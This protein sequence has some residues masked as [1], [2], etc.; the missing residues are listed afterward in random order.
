[1]F[2]RRLSPDAE[3]EM[4]RELEQAEQR[5]EPGEQTH[6]PG[7]DWLA[8]YSFREQRDGAD[9]VLKALESGAD[10]PW[11]EIKEA[12]QVPEHE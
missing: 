11:S 4:I 5:D 12:L 7:D 2:P 8:S 9:S 3:A 1:M 10:L 6:D